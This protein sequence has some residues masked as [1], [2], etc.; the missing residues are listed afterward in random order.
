MHKL[1]SRALWKEIKAKGIVSNK[2]SQKD[3][4]QI[5]SL[6]S[7]QKIYS[8]LTKGMPEPK[9]KLTYNSDDNSNNNTQHLK[10]QQIAAWVLRNGKE[11]G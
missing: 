7:Y 6:E 8:Y 9:N 4:E 11:I 2:I 3:I 5:I 10:Q 1:V